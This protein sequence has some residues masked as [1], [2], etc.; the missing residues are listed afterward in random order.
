MEAVLDHVLEEDPAGPVDDALGLP[1]GSRRVQDVE[2]V[3]EGQ[4]QVPDGPGRVRFQERLEGHA[5]IGQRRGVGIADDDDASQ[6][7]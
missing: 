3:V 5:A 2:G 7:G 6:G 1:G 4:V